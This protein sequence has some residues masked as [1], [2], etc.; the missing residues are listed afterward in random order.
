MWR[1]SVANVMAASNEQDVV[2]IKGL[3]ECG[4]GGIVVCIA[5]V[6]FVVLSEEVHVIGGRDAWPCVGFPELCCHNI[7]CVTLGRW[8]WLQQRQRGPHNARIAWCDHLG[9]GRAH[10]RVAGRSRVM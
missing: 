3:T 1:H 2:I 10:V 6:L 5:E 8:P 7:G 9:M 4:F